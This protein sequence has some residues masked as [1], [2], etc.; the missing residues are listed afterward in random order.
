MESHDGVEVCAWCGDTEYDILK[1]DFQRH[2]DALGRIG[3][4]T[5]EARFPVKRLIKIAAM[6][7]S[8]GDYISPIETGEEK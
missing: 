4:V 5:L 6:F 1:A 2:K 3:G 7:D 8:D